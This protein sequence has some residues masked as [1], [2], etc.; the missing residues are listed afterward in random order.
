MAQEPYPPMIDKVNKISKNNTIIL[1][2]SRHWADYEAT[3]RW[4]NKYGVVYDTL[5]M[6]KPLGNYYV[7]DKNMMMEEFLND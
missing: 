1:H 3:K 7:D 4:L 6:G 2:T 5:V